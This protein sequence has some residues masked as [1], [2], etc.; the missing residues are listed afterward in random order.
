M[1]VV[2]PGASIPSSNIGAI[3]PTRVS[4]KGEPGGTSVPQCAEPPRSPN[5][6]FVEYNWTSAVKIVVL[7]VHY[8]Q[9]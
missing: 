5:E 9:N 7:I 4:Y 3:L 8:F 1:L 6:I 2:Y